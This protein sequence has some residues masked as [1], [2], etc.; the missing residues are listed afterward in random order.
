MA[1]HPAPQQPVS[2]PEHQPEA[3]PRV[4]EKTENDKIAEANAANAAGLSDPMPSV[5]KEFEEHAKTAAAEPD[6]EPEYNGPWLVAH[7]FKY[8]DPQTQ[9][10][11]VVKPFRP[12]VNGGQE[13]RVIQPGDLPTKVAQEAW[14]EKALIVPTPV[15]PQPKRPRIGAQAR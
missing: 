2:P 14:A 12:S 5:R 9:A 10:P 11:V 3:K 13:R 15:A 4:D 1:K 6:E 8:T 7:T